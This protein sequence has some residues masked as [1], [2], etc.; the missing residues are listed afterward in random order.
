M[1][2]KRKNQYNHYTEGFRGEAGRRSGE[3]VEEEYQGT[4]PILAG[5]DQRPA[6]SITSWKGKGRANK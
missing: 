5:L 4:A 1:T 3:I 6:V 2:R